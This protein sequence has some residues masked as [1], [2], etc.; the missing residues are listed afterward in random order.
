M[1]QPMQFEEEEE[2]IISEL[3]P[4][5]DNMTYEELLEL[6]NQMGYVAKGLTEE[7]INVLMC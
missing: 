5:P 7:Q 4:N 1:M 2:N 3:Y 6:Q